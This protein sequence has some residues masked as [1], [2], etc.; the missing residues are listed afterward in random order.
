MDI[1]LLVL[2]VLLPFLCLGIIGLVLL[3]GGAGDI[4]S[5]FGGGGMLDSTLGVGASRKMAKVTGWLAGI[6]FVAVLILAI[7][8]KG[9]LGTGGLVSQSAGATATV[10]APPANR[11]VPTAAAAPVP[12]PVESLQAA[13]MAATAVPAK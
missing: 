2:Q 11:A 10:I 5:A 8:Y 12:V 1:L 7:P 9:S 4:S 6:F 13:P 3:Q